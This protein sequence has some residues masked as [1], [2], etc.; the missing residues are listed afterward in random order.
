MF[1][2]NS[3]EQTESIVELLFED[4]LTHLGG[5]ITACLDWTN[6]KDKFYGGTKSKEKCKELWW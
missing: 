2:V 1:M 4:I 5:A 6:Q 3:A